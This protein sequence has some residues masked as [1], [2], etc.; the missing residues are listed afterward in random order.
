[1]LHWGYAAILVGTFVEGETVLVLGG[2]AARRGYLALS[3]VMVAAFLG[4]LAG[5]QLFFWLGR[6]WG[7]RAVEKRPSWSARLAQVD[8]L[9][10][11]HGSL[12]LV[13]FRFLYG[14][15]TISP[16]AIGASRVPAARFIALDL[17]GC[18]AWSIAISSIGWAFGAAVERALGRVEHYERELFIL[19]AVVGLAIGV[20]ARTRRRRRA[21][22]TGSSHPPTPA[23]SASAS[24]GPHVPGS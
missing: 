21:Q 24:R 19:L 17:I 10:A 18:T 23:T 8:T 6:R 11:R 5:D 3:W 9:L 7:R 22:T 16:V 1:M 4:A 12:F 2:F 14:L 13:G 15:R 20:M